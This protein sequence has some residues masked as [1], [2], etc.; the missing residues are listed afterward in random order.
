MADLLGDEPLGVAELDQVGD[1][2]VPQAMQGEVSRQPGTLAQER[3]PA[4]HRLQCHSL[5]TLGQ[6]QLAALPRSQQ[7]SGLLDPLA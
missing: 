1:V 2:G 6:P 3:E 7:R 5:A 4:I